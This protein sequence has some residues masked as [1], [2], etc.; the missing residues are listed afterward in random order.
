MRA[1]GHN[2]PDPPP[3]LQ[4]ICSPSPT[5]WDMRQTHLHYLQDQGPG[6]NM[7]NWLKT[8]RLIAPLVW[9]TKLLDK[10]SG[11]TSRFPRMYFRESESF[12]PL[13]K[14]WL[15]RLRYMLP[16]RG[17]LPVCSYRQPLIN[18]QE[19]WNWFQS[20]NWLLNHFLK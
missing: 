15:C 9:I 14:P 7:S 17:C 18:C 5:V 2:W 20:R 19:K 13:I 6:Q 1:T 11:R 3:D 8:W 4:C 10:E 16:K 12:W